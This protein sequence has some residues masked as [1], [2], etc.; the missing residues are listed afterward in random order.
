MIS[1][2]ELINEVLDQTY[3]YRW[4]SNGEAQFTTDKGTDYEVVYHDRGRTVWLT[5]AVKSSAD[6]RRTGEGD[7]LKVLSTVFKT[8][9]DYLDKNRNK[10]VIVE[11]DDDHQQRIYEKI[12]KRTAS[13][14]KFKY[15]FNVDGDLIV[16]KHAD[17]KDFGVE[18]EGDY[19]SQ[20]DHWDPMAD[21]VPEVPPEIRREFEAKFKIGSRWKL[22]RTHP[23]LRWLKAANKVGTEFIVV[24]LG[25]ARGNNKPY[26]KLEVTNGPA[27]GSNVSVKADIYPFFSPA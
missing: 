10:G 12:L 26:A 11:G 16:T 25:R 17:L 22:I 21:F 2:R 15:D 13:R 14:Y 27:R 24:D 9:S 3:D 4:V 7:S 23:Y 1:A 8:M 18:S 6:R 20:F 19:F 5:F